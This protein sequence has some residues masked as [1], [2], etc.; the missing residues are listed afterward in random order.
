M[1]TTDKLSIAEKSSRILS[2]FI[3]FQL[4]L[5]LGSFLSAKDPRMLA[6]HIIAFIH[7]V[8][9]LM[10]IQGIVNAL[11]RSVPVRLR[12]YTGIIFTGGFFGTGLLLASYP[13][14]LKDQLAF[15][16]NMFSTDLAMAGVFLKEYLGISSLW[17]VA[18]AAVAGAVSLVL[19]LRISVP[20]SVR[21]IFIILV[22][23]ASGMTLRRSSP[24]PFVYSIQQELAVRIFGGGRVVPRL[25]RP[26]CG[27]DY[28]NSIFSSGLSD[29]S[30]LKADHVLLIVMEGVTAKDFETEFLGKKDGFYIR[31]KNNATYFNRYYTTNL[32]SYT[33]LIA[34][35]TGV[36]VPYRAY[37]D[38]KLYD[39]VNKARNLT[40]NL[41][42]LEYK[43]LFL[44]TYAHQPF[45]PVRTHWDRILDRGDL[46]SVDG[47]LTLG[48][49]RMET[50]TEDRAALP[51]M[52]KFI[53]GN[54]RSFLLHE[55]VYGHSPEWQSTTG[56]TASEYCDTYLTDLL[57]RLIAVGLDSSTL[58]VIVSD[59]GDRAKP[60]D[61][62]NYRIPLL[63]VGPG[64]EPGIREEFY[65]HLDLDGVVAHY[66]GG[67]D[68]PMSPEKMMVIGSTEK[69]VYGKI[70]KNRTH[71]FIDDRTGHVLAGRG[72][73]VPA[74]VHKDFQAYLDDFGRR[75]GK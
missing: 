32:D 5:H 21:F 40:E 33:S 39:A 43:T 37:A 65:S 15:P 18:L 73:V 45:V 34:M 55:M 22:V 51:D 35:L 47:W 67:T 52:M 36:Q 60:S 72:E 11:H 56:K 50:A 53:T 54:R 59:H 62:E 61:A 4:I 25:K 71:L 16:V 9:L 68:L 12:F 46:A 74:G 44:S 31:V 48:S 3:L 58:F 42:V 24:Q 23:I 49:S 6:P 41:R 27:A 70:F 64:V 1:N 10:V 75:F 69:W 13:L 66:L 8:L 57:D 38:D 14:L 7:D 17:P 20:R 63:V 2:A 26:E 28:T 19:P 30:E 29:S